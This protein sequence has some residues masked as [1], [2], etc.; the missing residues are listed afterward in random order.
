MA[1]HLPLIGFVQII[2][3]GKGDGDD[4]WTVEFAEEPIQIFTIFVIQYKLFW[5]RLGLRPSKLPISQQ[6]IP[7]NAIC[8]TNL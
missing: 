8:K 5:T 2:S 3:P 7:Y 1:Y 4:F 6:S